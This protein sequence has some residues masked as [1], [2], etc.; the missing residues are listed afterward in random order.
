ME[1]SRTCPS[2]R[3][4]GRS[5]QPCLALQLQSEIE[6]RKRCCVGRGR[7]EGGREG[8]EMGVQVIARCA[9]TVQTAQRDHL[10][11]CSLI[12]LQCE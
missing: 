3:T 2:A 5:C 10:R 8:E 4:P 9:C 12:M 1:L 7:E 11:L 6:G